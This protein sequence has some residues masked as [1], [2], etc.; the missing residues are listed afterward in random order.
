MSWCAYDHRFDS[1]IR[2]VE[3]GIDV[4]PLAQG[5]SVALYINASANQQMSYVR[6]QINLMA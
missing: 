5:D 4:L 2:L 1:H 3:P 6:N